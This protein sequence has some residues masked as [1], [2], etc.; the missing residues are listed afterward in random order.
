[1]QQ[2]IL[3][4]KA[5]GKSK[6]PIAKKNKCHKKGTK[7]CTKGAASAACASTT[8][9]SSMR[10]ERPETM[11]PQKIGSK[12]PDHPTVKKAKAVLTPESTQ[13]VGTTDRDSDAAAGDDVARKLNLRACIMGLP[14]QARPP[15]VEQFLNKDTKSYIVRNDGCKGSIQ[16]LLGSLLL[17]LESL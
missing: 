6:T 1:M 5:R 4:K 9:G 11:G 16:V 13:T 15:D 3:S 7:K 10:R 2:I 8:A 17:A 12:G 14:E